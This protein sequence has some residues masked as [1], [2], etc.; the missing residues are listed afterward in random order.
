MGKWCAHN[1]L[2][3]SN[4]LY[5]EALKNGVPVEPKPYKVDPSVGVMFLEQENRI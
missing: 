5:N 1:R 2:D 3:R 4:A